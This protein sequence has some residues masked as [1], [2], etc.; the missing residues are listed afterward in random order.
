M[1]FIFRT[2]TAGD[3]TIP[4]MEYDLSRKLYMDIDDELSLRQN[5]KASSVKFWNEDLPAPDIENEF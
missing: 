5:L 2:P 3:N 1:H 4:W